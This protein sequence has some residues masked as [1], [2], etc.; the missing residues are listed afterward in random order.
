M[1]NFKTSIFA[2]IG[3]FIY[4][5]AFN[6]HS[7]DL[8][9]Q[10]FVLKLTGKQKNKRLVEVVGMV[11]KS[12]TALKFLQ[13]KHKIFHFE[14]TMGLKTNVQWSVYN[15]PIRTSDKYSNDSLFKKL[16]FHETTAHM[17]IF[18]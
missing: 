11:N 9:W 6:P 4:K 3:P 12:A 2:L 15:T 16:E 1:S 8:M 5:R 18:C 10:Y 14:M 13:F 7:Y 17:T